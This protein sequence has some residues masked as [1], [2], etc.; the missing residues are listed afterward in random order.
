MVFAQLDGYIYTEAKDVG[1]IKAGTTYDIECE[2]YTPTLSQS[3]Q[4]YYEFG[5]LYKINNAGASNRTF[6]QVSGSFDEGDVILKER[7]YGSNTS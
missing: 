5:E 7:Q 3:T 1:T 2:I 4:A 6:S